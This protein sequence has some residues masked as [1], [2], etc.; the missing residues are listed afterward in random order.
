MVMNISAGLHRFNVCVC[1]RGRGRMNGR[2]V[3]TDEQYKGLTAAVH[4][5][6]VYARKGCGR[7]DETKRQ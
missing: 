5:Q 1:V 3:V 6:E 7:E 4:K 2:Q